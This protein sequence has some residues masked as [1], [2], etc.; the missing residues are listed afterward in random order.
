M[1][2]LTT[3]RI[4]TFSKWSTHTDQV[5]T[6]KI[7]PW[8]ASSLALVLGFTLLKTTIVAL[9]LNLYDYLIQKNMLKL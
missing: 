5:L 4:P 6:Q 1:A 3:P 2:V 7:M 8:V 9:L